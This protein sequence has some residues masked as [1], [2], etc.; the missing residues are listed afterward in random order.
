MKKFLIFFTLFLF[1]GIGIL[2]FWYWQRNIYSKEALKIEILA[3]ETAQAG[4]EIE[5]LVKLK[6]NGKIRLE[7]PQ[8]IFQAPEHSILKDYPTNRIIKEIEDIYPGEERTY[9]FLARL[10][11]P[12]NQ[13]MKAEALVIYQPKNLKASYESKTTFTSKIEFVPLT[14]EFDLPP[15]VEKEEEITLFLNY[16]SNLDYFLE[17]LRVKIQYPP[18]FIFQ[19]SS[20]QALDQTEWPLPSLTQASGGRIE[21]KG[22]IEGKE[23]EEKIFRAQLGMIKDGQ[24]LLLKETQQ[25]LKI[26]EPSIYLSFLIN[27]SQNYIAEAGDLLHYEIFF[28]NI[29]KKPIQKKFLLASL[30]GEFFDLF[31]LKSKKGEWGKGDNTILWDWK[32]ISDLRFL[33]VGQ[34]GKVEFW[35]KLKKEPPFKIKNPK[36][37]VK[38]NLAGLEKIFETKINSKIEF[39]QKVYFHQEFFQ[40][41]G[42]LPPQVGEKTEYVVVWQIKNSWNDLGKVKVKARLPKN[43]HLS[44]EI[45]P[46]EAKFTYDSQSKEVIWNIDEIPAWPA[47]EFLTLAFQ[48]ELLPDSSQQGETPLLIEEG[49]IFAQDLFTGEILKEKAEE[50]NTTL[51][52]DETISP[53][54]GIVE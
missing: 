9:S 6:N 49:E 25:S 13:T 20:P 35:V 11:G 1:I 12:E 18:G 38:I 3:P 21:I 10:F 37:K 41:Q 24:F 54:Q 53:Q 15:K 26:V 47:E 51:P 48:I 22:K 17:S 44:G 7:N 28:K 8:L 36:L 16:F 52:D 30:E 50:I 23:G 46:S 29:G 27:N 19:D 39:Y 2:G 5:Y 43:V 33:D 40:N 14:F 42:P 32:N 4:E 45:F 31:T 34:E